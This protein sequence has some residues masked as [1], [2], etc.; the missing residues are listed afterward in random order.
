MESR[1]LK[2]SEEQDEDTKEG[3]NDFKSAGGYST[4]YGNDGTSTEDSAKTEV[5]KSEV[6]K[7][8]V[9]SEPT[10]ED[11]YKETGEVKMVDGKVIKPEVRTL[12]TKPVV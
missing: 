1:H 10:A 5:P 9:S 7:E 3:M 12:F 8:S 4:T 2:T 6:K 11:V